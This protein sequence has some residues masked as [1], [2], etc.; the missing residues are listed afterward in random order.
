MVK[1]QVT[2]GQSRKLKHQSHHSQ[3]FFWPRHVGEMWWWSEWNQHVHAISSKSTFTASMAALASQDT[4]V[5]DMGMFGGNI[6]IY[7]N[8]ILSDWVRES[9]INFMFR[10]CI[11]LEVG[12]FSAASSK[13]LWSPPC[14]FRMPTQY[15]W[16]ERCRSWCHSEGPA[17]TWSWTQSQLAMKHLRYSP[18]KESNNKF[19]FESFSPSNFSNEIPVS[20]L[21]SNL[22]PPIFP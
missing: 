21:Y 4:N 1:L 22:W 6:Y 8:Q 20:G 15:A 7:K 10:V 12:I 18:K 2:P 17:V 11:S 14:P 5:E 13:V 3:W 19:C 9:S 16:L